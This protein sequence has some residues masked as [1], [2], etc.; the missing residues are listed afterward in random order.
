MSS[1]RE[2]TKSNA[3]QCFLPEPTDP[4]TFLI[5]E[6]YYLEYEGDTRVLYRVITTSTNCLVKEKIESLDFLPVTWF[7]P[8]GEPEVLYPR[9]WYFDMLALD[10]EVNLLIAKMNNIVKTGGRFVY[11]REGTVMHKATSQLMNS[12]GIEVIEVAGSQALP[13][14]ATLLQISAEMISWLQFLMAQADMEGGMQQDIMGASS[15]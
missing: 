12:L 6:G 2:R 7:A 15:T 3:K 5:R 13:E 10:R 11:V 4:D 14:Q 1:D 8:L 9:S